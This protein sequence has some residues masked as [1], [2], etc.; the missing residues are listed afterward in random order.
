MIQLIDLMILSLILILVACSSI[1]HYSENMASSESITITNQ[2]FDR[3]WN[4]ALKT[5]VKIHYAIMNTNKESGSIYALGEE[6]YWSRTSLPSLTLLISREEN[7][8]KLTC[9]S[10]VTHLAINPNKEVNKFFQSFS[11]IINE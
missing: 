7:A 6:G 1:P 3:V 5:L 8:I 2:S 4:S 9:L 11:E 10:N